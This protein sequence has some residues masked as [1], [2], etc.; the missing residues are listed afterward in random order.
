M[1]LFEKIFNYQIVSRLEDS[2][3]FMI[4]S[5]ERSWL[6][7]MLNH[8]AATVAFTADTLTKLNSILEPDEVMD[9]SDHLIEKARSLEKQVYHPFLRPLS[10]MIMN[11]NG[12]CLTYGIKN[13][14]T[15]S[16]QSGFP[17]KLEYSMVKREW[18]L[19][20][21]HLRQ[22]KFMR[23]RLQSIVS[24]AE[25]SVLPSY[26]DEIIR[27][28]SRQLEVRQ[29]EIVIEVIRDY[30]RELSRILYALSSFEKNVDYDAENDK[31]SVRITLLSDESE[32]LLS[33]LRFLGKRVRII[34]GDY[35][36]RRMLES[37]TKALERYESTSNGSHS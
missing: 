9:T 16:E 6:K 30:N 10:R 19:L 37:S 4:S 34:Q 33:K 24:V 13:G 20:W 14:G 11:K 26:A 25:E 35:M 3:T 21:Y 28:I 1:N 17:Y 36:K 18:Y 23:T 22:H 8:P 29:I 5:H 27:K 2:G 7:T 12:I 31:Y 32:Y 15:H